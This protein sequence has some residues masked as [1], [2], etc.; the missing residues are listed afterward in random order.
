MAIA[1]L[2]AIKGRRMRIDLCSV[3]QKDQRTFSY[4]SQATGLM[5]DLDIGT[6]HLRWMGSVRFAYGYI[7]GSTFAFFFFVVNVT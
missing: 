6:N 4:M 3:T 7:R 2:N 1:T 5:A